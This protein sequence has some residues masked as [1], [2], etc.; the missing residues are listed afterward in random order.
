MGRH[1]AGR[2][3]AVGTPKSRL[4]GAAHGV[5]IQEDFEAYALRGNDVGPDLVVFLSGL[6]DLMNRAG[7]SPQEGIRLYRKSLRLAAR[8]GRHQGVPMVF[9]TQPFLGGKVHKTPLPRALPPSPPRPPAG[10]TRD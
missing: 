7:G 2:I 4:M 8:L 9:A 6:N 1:Q 3:S 5:T 10:G